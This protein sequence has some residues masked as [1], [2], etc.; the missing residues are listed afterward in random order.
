MYGGATEVKDGLVLGSGIV[1]LPNTGGNTIGTFLAYSAIVIG[2][3]AL[4]SH[5]TVRLVRRAHAE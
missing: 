2:G 4:L 5:L 3:V 1:I